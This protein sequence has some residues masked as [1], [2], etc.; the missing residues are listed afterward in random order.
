MYQNRLTSSEY[1]TLFKNAGFEI[2]ELSVTRFKE[3]I[4]F[5]PHPLFSTA[6]IEELR[7]IGTFIV[8]R[9]I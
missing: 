9:R 6:G 5:I 8:L 7:K 2:L 3:N 1:V 4:D